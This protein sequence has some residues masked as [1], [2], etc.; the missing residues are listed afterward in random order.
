MKPFLKFGPFAFE[1][2][3][4]F[5]NL[6][7]LLGL[8]VAYLILEKYCKNEKNYWKLLPEILLLMIISIPFARSIKGAFN[9]TFF[10]E[11]T[12]FLGRVLFAVI[13]LFFLM[14]FF[15]KDKKCLYQAWNAVAAYFLV[16]HFFNRIA[17]WLNGC[18][19]GIYLETCNIRF[20]SQLFEAGVMLLAFGMLLWKIRKGQWFYYQ[21]CMI[22]AVTIFI[23][24]F[25]IEQPEVKK[26]LA[27]TSVQAGAVVLFGLAAIWYWSGQKSEKR[28]GYGATK[29]AADRM[30]G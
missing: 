20:P 21:S 27:L 30:A 26:I 8:T 5:T 28:N 10:D 2:Y 6:G 17:C 11:A 23:S 13:V 25:F 9:G 14:N 24:E 12:H 22:Y 19:G 1:S 16:Q 3:T 15:W 18:C 4:L 7:T 29:E